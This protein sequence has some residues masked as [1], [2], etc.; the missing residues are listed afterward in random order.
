VPLVEAVFLLSSRGV[1]CLGVF[2]G[3]QYVCDW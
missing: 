3:V 2:C 1:E